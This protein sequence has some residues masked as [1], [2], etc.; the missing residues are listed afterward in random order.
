[1]EFH[2]KSI[3]L[4]EYDYAQPGGYFVTIVTMRREFLFVKSLVRKC[5]FP[6]WDS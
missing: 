1:M 3:R 6:V 2:C 4:K 5:I